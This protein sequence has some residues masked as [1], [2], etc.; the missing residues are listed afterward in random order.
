MMG[1]SCFFWLAIIHTHQITPSIHPLTPS[2]NL[3]ASRHL[4]A[5]F[6]DEDP[7]AVVQPHHH[8]GDHGVATALV[9]T[10]TEKGDH[11][12]WDSLL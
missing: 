2:P 1:I 11:G 12:G 7:G 9:L 6:V 4:D 5:A 3:G 10:S 8:A